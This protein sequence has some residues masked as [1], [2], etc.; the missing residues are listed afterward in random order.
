MPALF[1]WK[2][3]YSVQVKL[4]D[5]QHQKLFAIMNE[6]ADAMRAGQGS[7][8]VSHTVGELLQYA[9]THFQQEEAL[10]RRANYAQLAAHQEMHRRFVADVELLDRQ[11]REGHTASSVQ[12][13][14]ILRDWLV[15]HIQKTD[16]AYSA[17]L[18][19]AGIH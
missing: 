13:L 5:T 16:K 19:A 11:T 9:R 18:N 6:L 12:V 7:T 14:N 3:S 15:N 2:D 8:A 4:C 1:T 17:P 10:M